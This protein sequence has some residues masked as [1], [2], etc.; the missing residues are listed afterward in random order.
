MLSHKQKV[1]QHQH[2]AEQ[3]H[4]RVIT[5]I[6]RLEF[7]EV[8]RRLAHKTA[9]PVKEA[10]HD[11]FIHEARK[12]TG[13]PTEA[14]GDDRVVE[15][16]VPQIPIESECRKSRKAFNRSN[17]DRLLQFVHIPFAIEEAEHETET[18][19]RIDHRHHR[20]APIHKIRQENSEQPNARR[21]QRHRQIKITA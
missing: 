6:A 20:A 7:A 5:H 2:H 19:Q 8:Q 18:L 14:T 17:D 4:Q 3:N 16:V 21:D 11:P 13:E 1:S 15:K 10:I 12:E 9:E